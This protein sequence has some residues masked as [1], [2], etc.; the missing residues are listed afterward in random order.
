M[1]KLW[2]KVVVCV[3]AL[4]ILFSRP[5]TLFIVGGVWSSLNITSQSS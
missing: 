3:S 2:K 1:K 4:T 5:D